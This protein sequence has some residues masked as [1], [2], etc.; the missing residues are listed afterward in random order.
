MRSGSYLIRRYGSVSIYANDSIKV[1]FSY[2]LPGRAN[3]I[4]PTDLIGD[5]RI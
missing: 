1:P 4:I 3:I 5:W 2:W